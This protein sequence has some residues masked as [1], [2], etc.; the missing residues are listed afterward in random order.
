VEIERS[1]NGRTLRCSL[2]LVRNQTTYTDNV[3]L[4]SVKYYYRL[5]AVNQIGESGASNIA[6]ATTHIGGPILQVSDI[7]DMQ[8][9]LS[10]T[11]T[12]PTDGH[13]LIVRS[14]DG[15]SFCN[16]RQCRW[17]TTQFTDGVPVFGTYFLSRDG[18]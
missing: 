4:S 5:R 14:T 16:R 18:F 17:N 8:I 11:A 6:F 13:Y 1:F 2:R 7:F 10:W 9:S 15:V 12:A 3:L